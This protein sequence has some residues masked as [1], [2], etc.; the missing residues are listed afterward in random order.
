MTVKTHGLLM[1]IGF[2]LAGIFVF[3]IFYFFTFRNNRRYRY[4]FAIE[5]FKQYFADDQWI[6]IGHDVFERTEEVAKE[7]LKHQCIISGFG[8]VL[9]EADESPQLIITP[10]RHE[11][12]QKQRKQ[13]QFVNRNETLRQRT[14]QSA[15]SFWDRIWSLFAKRS[16]GWAYLR[17][18]ATSYTRLILMSMSIGLLALI[19]WRQISDTEYDYLS[20]K[21]WTASVE[22]IDGKREQNYY[23]AGAGNVRSIEETGTDYLDLLTE[24][25]EDNIDPELSNIEIF[26]A[27]DSRLFTYY[28]CTR[29][30]NFEEDKYL[31]KWASYPEFDAAKEHVIR[32]MQKG[33]R[34][35]VIWHGCFQG[36]QEGY[37]VFLDLL[38]KE[39]RAAIRK[40]NFL[41]AWL[42][43]EGEKTDRMSIL[44]IRHQ[45]QK[46]EF[47]VQF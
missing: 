35:N 36:T 25:S 43:Q 29:L 2:V 39:E 24:Y 13:L 1:N 37:I 46:R 44:M 15:K 8:L 3:G 19:F 47:K 16:G 42:A 34:C 41:K 6:A 40:A 20:D 14:Y 17:F 45:E 11:V 33:I 7:E 32:L 10:A 9:I 38:Y 21:E 31:I 26:M 5:Q 22:T 12:F 27:S 30:Y 18:Q 23:I 28:D 4:I